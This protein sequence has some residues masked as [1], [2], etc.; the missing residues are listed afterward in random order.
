MDK[1]LNLFGEVKY[2][3]EQKKFIEYKGKD[4]VI[5]SAVA[6]SGKTFSCVQR[7]N[8]LLERGV[9]PQ[10][11]IFFSFTKAATDELI[12]RVKNDDITIT[13]I[14]AFSLGLLSKMGKFKKISTFY[15]FLKWFKKTYQPPHTAPLESRQEFDE[16]FGE[17]FDEMDFISSSISAY[18]LQTADGVKCKLPNH[19]NTYQDFLKKT[20]S[21]DFSDMLIEVRELLKED[22]WLKMFRGK[23]DYIFIDEYQDTS[24]I[25][26]QILLALNAKYYY[27]I[28]DKNQSI[29]GYSGANSKVIETMLSTRRSVSRMTL[30]VNF[31]SD[32]NIVENSNRFS[33]IQAVPQ[34]KEEGFIKNYIIFEIESE[35][36]INGNKKNLDL[37]NVLDKYSEVAV[38]VRTNVVI[39]NI[40]F[41]LLKRKYPM[42][43]FN[44][45][46]ENDFKEWKKGNVLNNL[47]ARLKKLRPFFNDNDGEIFS[48]IESNK[49]FRKFVTS[50]HK[51]KGR[52]FD[53]CVV[54]NS[55]DPHLV[56]QT[57][58][59]RHLGKKQLDKITFDINDYDVEPKNI[60]YVAMTRAKH[61][62]FY[63]LYG[64]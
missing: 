19:F 23:Y 7:L 12:K 9:D 36:D 30:S 55:I 64:F 43:Y 15:D 37:I 52:E 27:I 35:K 60:H 11:I 40:E 48:F 28:G 56:E 16:L 6:G 29:Y 3:E 53:Y 47:E 22:K 45:I 17:M 33:E 51:S 32:I 58:L 31:R 2:T 38:L 20:K 4:S 61:G 50:I 54:V 21:R 5:L 1:Q 44:Y 49:K 63:M 10:R 57:G 34:S 26:L 59:S 39:R 24:T 42:R 18:K 8:V 62:C 13:T 41:E 46:T 25:Q 14:H